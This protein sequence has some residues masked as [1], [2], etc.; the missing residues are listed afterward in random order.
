MIIPKG[1]GMWQRE[2]SD[3]AIEEH[4]NE[5]DIDNVWKGGMMDRLPAMQMTGLE[6]GTV[7]LKVTESWGTLG[8]ALARLRWQVSH[9]QMGKWKWA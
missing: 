8:V 7:K 4:G 9:K 5:A 1:W 6:L 2:V 3:G